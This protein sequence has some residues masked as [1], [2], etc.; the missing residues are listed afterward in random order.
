MAKDNQTPT[1]KVST[2]D[3]QKKMRDRSKPAE[4]LDTGKDTGIS[5]DVSQGSNSTEDQKNLDG[6]LASKSKRED[7][8]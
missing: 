3:S 4:D 1:P 6:R 7:K 5:N 2:E 8:P